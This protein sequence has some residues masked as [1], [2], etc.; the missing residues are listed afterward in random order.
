MATA[1]TLDF[2][3]LM[4]KVASRLFDKPN[5]AMSNATTL[6][7]GTHGSMAINLEE[8]QFYDH[9]AKSGGG[10]LELIQRVKNV[11]MAGALAWLEDEGLKEREKP[12]EKVWQLGT[13]RIGPV[14]YDY[15]DEA[16]VI[17]SR[18]KR[19]PDKRFSQLGPDGKGGFHSASGCMTGV[20]RVP[21]RLP[22]LLAADVNRAVFI[23]EGE[24]DADRLAAVGLV[25]S[26]NAEG[27]GKFRAELAPHFASRMVVILPDNDKAGRDHANDVAAKLRGVAKVV[28][29]LCLPDLGP[30][31]DVSDW[32]D[33]GG[34]VD[35]L[36]DLA[37]AALDRPITSLED[38]STDEPANDPARLISATP[39]VWRE[40][41][42]IKPREWV[43]GRS[44][45]RGHLR[46]VVAQGG[47][48]KTI[49][50]VG[51]ALAMVTGRDLLGHA[52]PGGP[53]RVWLW[54]LE[55]DREELSRIIQAACKHWNIKP[56]DVDGRLFVDSAL[57]GAI[58]KLAHS[59]NADGL[60]INR[61]LV[62]ALTAEMMAREIDYLHI[63]PFVSSHSANES[64][65][66][67]IDAIA[68]EWAL[69]AKNANAGVG[70]AHHVS[71]AG[72]MEAT[73][74]SARGAVALINACRSVLVLNRMN[75][76]EAKRYGIEDERRR[77][78]FRV[79]DDKNNR[80]PPS[81]QSDWYQ[82]WS[83]N[84]GNGDDG[85]GD[86]IGV[87]VPW[88]PP[89][90][91]EGVTVDHLRRVQAA[92]DAGEYK[93]HHSA[94]DWAGVAVASVF[95][96]DVQDKAHKARILKM[97]NTWEANGA[98]KVEE[99]KDKNRQ[100]KKFLVVGRWADDLS[101]TPAPSVASQG[102]A[103][104]QQSATLHPAP[105][106]G[107]GV[108]SAATPASAT[109]ANGSSDHWHDNPALGRKNG[110]ILA[111]G[112]SLDDPVPGWPQ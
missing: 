71:K 82:M 9:E 29:I 36:K 35:K 18:V 102:V 62:D 92:I 19:T 88:S 94:E 28:T 72:A 111:P 61:P 83:V 3:G 105:Y 25:A 22:E 95:G 87:V 108:A 51:E 89:D 59:T 107:V 109:G 53:K 45:Q 112:E 57:D 44:I 40:P 46:A 80:A 73:A 7:F 86:S 27:S 96:L 91:F 75:E 58:L 100:W 30:K 49:L 13:R 43:Y 56:A 21:Y 101:A 48:G 41:A 81:D 106:R 38:A 66:M 5:K 84:L 47:A 64:D 104:S 70:L 2:A 34:T 67:E 90:A 33:A 74:L 50:S 23:V 37:R 15:R 26:C 55:D 11:D 1:S 42:A 39:Y 20:R 79:Y 99:R 77:R 78:F 54:N 63:D 14:F 24:K 12:E 10:V 110:I 31:E 76:E 4:P 60:V 32:L 16:G 8:G 65:N 98:L 103:A 69:V 52:I 97:L 6:R 85:Y 93:A 17:L 68:K